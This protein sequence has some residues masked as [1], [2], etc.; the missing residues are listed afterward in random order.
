M[1][2]GPILGLLLSAV[3]LTMPLK[4]AQVGS[5]LYGQY[6]FLGLGLF[7]EV[8]GVAI[9]RLGIEYLAKMKCSVHLWELL[10]KLLLAPLKCSSASCIFHI[11]GMWYH[12]GGSGNGIVK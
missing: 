9:R 12:C 11:K 2:S 6:V 10:H 3:L 8:R 1:E 7:C 4:M 5:A